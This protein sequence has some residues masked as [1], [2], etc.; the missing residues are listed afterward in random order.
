MHAMVVEA[1]AIVQRDQTPLEYFGELMHENWTQEV[2]LGS[3]FH[4]RS[5]RYTMWRDQRGPSV[6]SCSVQA[7]AVSSVSL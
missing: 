7:V 5:T 1:I 3:G 2:S 6:E 4:S